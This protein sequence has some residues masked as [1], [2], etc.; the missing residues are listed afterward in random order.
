M[1][2]ADLSGY[3]QSIVRCYECRRYLTFK[4]L[5]AKELH[6]NPLCQDC[7]SDYE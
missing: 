2:K 1:K 3:D 6:E 4:E 7:D 5:G